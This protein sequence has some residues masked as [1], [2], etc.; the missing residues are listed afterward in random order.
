MGDKYTGNKPDLPAYIQSH[1]LKR[2]KER[3][4][5]LDRSAIN[6]ALWEN[7]NK[8]ETLE[9]YRGYVLLPFKVF[10][11]KI[12]YLAANILEEK[13]IFR[14]F[15][16]ITHSC[17]PEGD[18][19]NELTG[20]GKQDISYWKIDRLSTFVQ[21]DEEKYPKLH[22]L[23]SDAGLGEL[24]QLKHKEFNIEHMQTA[25]LDGLRNYLFKGQQAE[26]IQ[27]EEWQAFLQQA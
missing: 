19:L 6:Y 13:L 2:L 4:D 10:G 18:C 23:F 11:I 16:F 14:T 3:L 20:L 1:A 15:L 9:H 12:G 8:I 21:L 26:K 17:T 24:N 5:L 27:E 7:T 22:K 25:N